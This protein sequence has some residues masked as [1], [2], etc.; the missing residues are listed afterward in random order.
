MLGRMRECIA[1]IKSQSKQVCTMHCF[2]ASLGAS[3]FG[4]ACAVGSRRVAG[5]PPWRDQV[6]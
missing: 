6:H 5:A 1:L 3:S 2:T 4:F